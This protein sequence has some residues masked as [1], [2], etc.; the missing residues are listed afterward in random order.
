MSARFSEIRPQNRNVVHH[1]NM[2]YVSIA[3]M[4]GGDDTFITGYVP[5]G[6]PMDRA[7]PEDPV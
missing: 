2:A 6:Q 5:G 4:K 3:K 1:C 7:L